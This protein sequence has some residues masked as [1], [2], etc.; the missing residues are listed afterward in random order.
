MSDSQPQVIY[1]AVLLAA[2]LLL[3]GLL[4]RELV[5]LV[6]AVLI[7]I[8]IAIPLSAGA[9]RLERVGIPRAIGALA[10]LL[11][12]VAVLAGVLALII[13]TFT[14]EVNKFVD[15]VPNT[16]NDFERTVGHIVGKRP[17]EVGDNIQDYLKRYTNDPAKLISPITSIG[18][19]V[20]GVFGALILML[21]TAYYMAVRPEPLVAGA[22]RLVP[23]AGRE[24]TRQIMD[25]LRASWIGWMKGVLIH[26]F[27]S[28]TLLYLGLRIVGLDFALVFAVLTALLVVIPYLGVVIGAVPPVMFALTQSPGKALLVF[29]VYVGVHEIEA[30]LIIPVVMGRA[31]KLHPAVIA[32]GVV[33]VERLFGLVGLIVA[34]PLI[35]TIVI[36]VEEV[37]VKTI[38]AAIETADERR[39]F[40]VLEVPPAPEPTAMHDRS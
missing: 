7:T 18:I 36:L 13:P 32:V 34:V 1:R 9:T 25:R 40:E 2:F 6:L 17:S 4:F 27:L 5:T 12:G 24:R 31:T 35:T 23:P 16:V 22:L 3:L 8:I 26:M 21:I 33:A 10:T 11:L 39:T 14:H 29:A 28:G 15:Q 20:V 37:W 30:N 38:E 19:S